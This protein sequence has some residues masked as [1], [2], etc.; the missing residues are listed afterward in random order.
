MTIATAIMA[1]GTEIGKTHLACELLRH[2]V[3]Q[4][5]TTQAIKPVMSGFDESELGK[6]DAGRLA[7]AC[8]FEPNIK[9]VEDIC[10]HRFTPELAPNVA[11]RQVGVTLDYEDILEFCS[12]RLN[13]NA[14]FKLLEGAGGL[15]SPL[16][17]HHLNA[18]LVADLK[19]PTLLV[20]ASYLGSISHTLSTLES[21]T[22]R[23]IQIS[24]IVISKPGPNFGDEITFAKEL[25]HWCDSPI[26]QMDDTSTLMQTLFKA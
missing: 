1:T 19:L 17:D 12:E 13:T 9:V 10:L 24:A 25:Q 21:A 16:T 20:T 18:D 23:N 5:L 4:G 26:I 8:G 7:L 11:A 2:A 6:S 3:A 15:L 14:D 22:K